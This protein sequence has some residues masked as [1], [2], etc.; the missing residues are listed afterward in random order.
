LEALKEVSD[1]IKV[2]WILRIKNGR[3]VLIETT[4][5]SVAFENTLFK[6]SESGASN[7]LKEKE[8]TMAYC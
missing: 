5:P 2:R 1:S 4:Y 3:L 8:L 7:V 6:F